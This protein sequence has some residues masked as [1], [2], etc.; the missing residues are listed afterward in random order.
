MLID[1][2]SLVRRLR[3]ERR[4]ALIE[5]GWNGLA[6][7]WGAA[8]SAIGAALTVAKSMPAPLVTTATTLARRVLGPDVVPAYTPDLPSG[9]R[10]RRPR[11]S[12][13]PAAVY[14]P[15]CIGTVFAPADGGAGVH[16]A[17]L[18]LAGRAGLEL[19]IPDGIADMCCGTPWKSKGYPSALGEMRKRVLRELSIAAEGGR[20]PVISDATSCT[21]GLLGLVRASPP[22]LRV[23]DAVAWV[24]EHVLPRLTIHRRSDSVVIHPTCSSTHLGI[25]DALGRLAAA[26]ARRVVVPDDWGCC[27]F[28]GDRGMLHPELTASATAAE[29]VS[30]A[31][32]GPFAAHVSANRTCELGMSRATGESYRHV[33]ELLAWAT[34]PA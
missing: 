23:V 8:G 24:D 31:V 18:A 16:D 20:L 30:V 13:D 1:T 2:G 9:G 29:A 4:G 22:G 10:R 3:A 21:E 33:L 5:T 15:S 19:R 26:A 17:L 12:H 7:N 27:G 6:K 25:D 28:A 11:R 32:A 14:V 34:E